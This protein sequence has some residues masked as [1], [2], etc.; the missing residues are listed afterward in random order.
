MKDGAGSAEKET[1]IS[2]DI[3]ELIVETSSGKNTIAMPAEKGFYILNLKKDTVVG[4][5]L[6]L[7]TD[8]NSNKV[9][10][11]EELKVKI[12]S[13][14]AMTAGANI[15]FKRNFLIKPGQLLKVS[16]NSDA[17][18]Y[19]PYKKIPATLDAGKDGKDPE[20]YKFYTNAEIRDLIKNLKELSIY[21]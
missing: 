2:S 4:S 9:M 7:G 20:I 13:L 10:T 11:Q 6:Q 17:G 8:L 16:D 5:Q 15:N 3:K 18:V 19:G 12:D 21:K 1:I 14:I